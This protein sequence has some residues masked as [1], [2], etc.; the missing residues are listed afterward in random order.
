MRRR[1]AVRRVIAMESIPF[2]EPGTRTLRRAADALGGTALSCLGWPERPKG[3][4]AV[5]GALVGGRP[6]G[7]GHEL[8]LLGARSRAAAGAG[9]DRT[10]GGSAAEDLDRDLGDLRGRAPDAHAARLQGL[11]LGDGRA[12][13]A[14]AD[15]ARV[16]HRL[17][18][19]C[20]E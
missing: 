11:G 17:A 6:R 18:R 2:G 9:G 4:T 3:R 13:R 12:L 8:L 16:A 20:V 1:R 7:R 15:G 19:L 10:T 14:A 5:G